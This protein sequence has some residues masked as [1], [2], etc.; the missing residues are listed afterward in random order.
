MP[1][2]S[3][4]VPLSSEHRRTLALI[5]RHPTSHNI[6][7]HDI[8]SLL[9]AIGSV[10]ESS[11]GNHVVTIGSQ[12]QTFH[13]GQQKDIDAEQLADLRQMLEAAGYDST[14]RS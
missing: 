12:R 7:W 2:S 5:F 11:R 10:D 13:R 3:D 4:S 14:S 6:E 8:L 9:E 1:S